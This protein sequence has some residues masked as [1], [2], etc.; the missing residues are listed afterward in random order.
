[1]PL[2]A[3]S[4]SYELIGSLSGLELT[5]LIAEQF[6]AFNTPVSQPLVAP[7]V[8]RGVTL[9]RV[10]YA[11][12]VDNP[13]YPRRQIVSGLLMVP[14]SKEGEELTGERPLAIYNH[15]TL[16]SREQA[17][18]NVVF[19]KDG[20]WAVGS[21]ETLFNIGLLA[22]KGYA[23]I[24]ADYVGYGI[25][26]MPEGY[27]VKNPSITAIVDFLDASRSVLSSL[28]VRPSQLFLNGWSQGGMNTQ[29]AVQ[30]LET[31]QIPVAA[32][33]VESPFNEFAQTFDWWLSRTM[34]DPKQP[35]DPGPWLPLC[36]GILLR[37]YES[38]HG[39]TGLLDAFVKDEVIPAAI[40]SEG[41]LVENPYGVT[42][43][44]VIDRFVK[45]G[46]EVV[47]FESPGVFS[48]DSWL[49]N[50]LRD[51][52]EVWTTIPGFTNEEMLAG[53]ALDNGIVREFLDL[54]KAD[55]PRYW[56]YRTP[57]KAWYGLDDEAL[58]PELV[59]P[60]MAEVGGPKV[61][62]VPVEGASHRQTFLNALV[63]SAEN[64]AGTNENLIDWFQSFRKDTPAS[65]SLV[66]SGNTLEVVSQ[67]FGLLPLL[68]LAEQQQGERPLHVQISRIRKDGSSEVIG[69]LG[70]T[71]ASA[72]Q[73]QSLGDGRL[74]LQVGD[75]LGFELL[76][77]AGSEVVG[78]R[79]EIVAD[80]D[81][82]GYTVVVRPELGQPQASLRINL[83][84]AEAAFSPSPLDRIA[85]PQSTAADGLLQLE[86]GQVLT[87]RVSSDC[88]FENRLGFV[89]LNLD[90][91]TGLPDYTVGDQRIAINSDAFRNQIDSLLAPGFQHRQSGRRVEADLQWE[92]QQ[93]GL[94]APVMITPE[95]D[96]FSV[97]SANSGTGN[98]SHLR[99]LGR[100]QFGFEDLKA[101]RADWD[102]NDAVI[103]VTGVL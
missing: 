35:L 44:E 69:T 27:A 78:S 43:R 42:Y 5:A 77:R 62:L 103:E 10:C 67:D 23:L 68:L 96:V 45:F 33:A 100:N 53:G 95:G 54:F 11:I 18:T 17:A 83:W 60:G 87:M 63:A 22:D 99:L 102:W 88:A 93:G 34:R 9:Y 47:S 48:N 28:G 74:L 2:A 24:A 25:N 66:L 81:D 65:A 38:W 98:A 19:N 79:T 26:T 1:M 73:L 37:S 16:F 51:G 14:E 55:S 40:S 6:P 84:A 21:A 89:R 15:G 61:T 101:F 72:N 59:A 58:S 92:V 90:A 76:A 91:I 20:A 64:P 4:V 32:A 82:R 41:T 13:E 75:R 86:Q 39:L 49:V 12:D 50:V 85:A 56:T 36:M 52:K 7:K 3:S 46:A 30:A 8:S 29:W 31:L 71:T 70:G 80:P 57:L 97:G 94:F